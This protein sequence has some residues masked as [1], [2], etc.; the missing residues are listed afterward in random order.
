M[1]IVMFRVILAGVLAIALYNFSS[2]PF[3]LLTNIIGA[4][5]EVFMAVLFVVL[6]KPWVND[7]MLD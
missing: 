1:L 3:S 7:M 6:I 4:S 5:Q 2:E